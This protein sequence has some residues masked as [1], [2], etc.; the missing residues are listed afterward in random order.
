MPKL[1]PARITALLAFDPAHPLGFISGFFLVL[2]LVLLLVL[3]LVARRRAARTWVLL[4]FSLYFYYK[5][6]GAF[7]ALLILSAAVD[8]GLGLVLGS[9]DRPGRRRILLWTGVAANLAV[10][11][12]F[13]YTRNWVGLFQGWGWLREGVGAMAVPVGVS[14]Y[15]FQKISYLADVYRRKIGAIRRPADFLLYTAFFPRVVAGPIVRAGEFFTQLDQPDAIFDRNLNTRASTA[16]VDPQAKPGA[17][18]RGSNPLTGTEETD[19][20][21]KPGAPTAAPAADRSSTGEAFALILSGLFKKAVIAD[22][23]GINFVDRV[24]AA[25]GLYSG[26]ENLL[27]VYG[28]AIQ[29]YCDFSGYTDIALGLGRLAGL[30]LPPNFRAPYKATTVSDFWTRWH[31]TLSFWL[32]D[33]LF[34]PLAFRLSSLIKSERLA[35][36]RTDKVIPTLVTVAVF[37]VCGL[38]HG[39]AWGFVVWGG[40]H[41]LAVAVERLLRLPQK[42]LRSRRRR[43]VGR[44]LT[45]HYIGLAWIFFRADK[46]G[47]GGAILGQIFGHFKIRLL[48]QFIAGYPLVFALIALGFVLHWAPEKLKGTVRKVVVEAPLPFLAIALAAM[49]WLVFQFRVADIQPFIYFKF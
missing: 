11:V 19:P 15:T 4:A 37:I 9:T 31:I 26:L 5:T 17:P 22:F 49:I 45:F 36:L 24:F 13:K 32:R 30:R 25:P 8:F 33:Y 44:V 40:L 6:G 21:A 35:G 2:V 20:Q 12:Y 43:V 27:A 7:V 41:G 29:I 46:L 48:P 16:E 3:P 23:I 14:Y 42:A 1:D 39:A 28:Y 38:W 18:S 34:W 10:L 47:T